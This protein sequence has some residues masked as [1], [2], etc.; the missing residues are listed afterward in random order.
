MSQQPAGDLAVSRGKAEQGKVLRRVVNAK[1][2]VRNC[3][4][5]NPNGEEVTPVTPVTPGARRESA[6]RYRPPRGQ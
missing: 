4:T 3:E 6:K 5:A 2:T 1:V